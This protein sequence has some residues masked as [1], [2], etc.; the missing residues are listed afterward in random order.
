MFEGQCVKPQQL[1]SKVDELEQ[2]KDN[3]ETELLDKKSEL[4]EKLETGV[5]SEDDYQ[6][7]LS[8]IEEEIE[9]QIEQIDSALDDAVEDLIIVEY[10]VQQETKKLEST[11]DIISEPK[12]SARTVLFEGQCIA[13]SVLAE[14]KEILQLDRDNLQIEFILEKSQLEEKLENAEISDAIYQ[15]QLAK[16]ENDYEK[17][18]AQIDEE[19]EEIKAVS[20]TVSEPEPGGGCLI[21]TAAYGSELAPQVQYLREIRDNTLYSTVSGSSFMTSFNQLYYLFSPTV[22]DWERQNPVFQE[23]VRIFIT[24]MLST[25]S[26]MTL[27]EDGNDIQVLGLG[28]SVITLNIGIYIA[29]PAIAGFKIHR[30]LKSRN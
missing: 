8:S 5:L 28:I 30:Y 20:E 13:Q 22:A 23:A 16:L 26:L 1:E 2:E 11:L 17:Q 29:V 14:N 19:I 27:A 6:V 25:L 21:A 7:E 9:Q 12:C 24:P 10:I 3:L 4:D 18:L 15:V